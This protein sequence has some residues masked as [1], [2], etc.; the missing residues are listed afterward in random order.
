MTNRSKARGTAAESAITKVLIEEGWLHAERR[1]LAGAADRGDIN[2]GGFPVMIESKRCQTITI[3][4]WLREVEAEKSNARAEI[5]VVWHW[6]RGK[7]D[8]RDWAVTMS[9]AQFMEILK[10]LG[11]HP[12]GPR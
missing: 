6:I 9:G 2:L 8:P 5:G 7:G 11:Y 3:P 12:G 4:A 1:V 10:K